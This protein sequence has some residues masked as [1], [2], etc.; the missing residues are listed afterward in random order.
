ME[1]M[2]NYIT[3]INQAILSKV[4][5]VPNIVL[6]GE[7]LTT[8]SRISGLTRNL[9]VRQGGYIINVGN[10]EATHC[11]VGF[12]LMMSGVTSVLFVKQLDFMLLGMDHF[13]NT[14]NFIRCQFDPD[15]Y[16]SFTIIAIVC[17]QGYQGPHSSFNAL[18]DM[19]SVARVPGYAITNKRDLQYIVD[20]QLTTPGFRFVTLSQKMFPAEFL[21]MRLVYSAEDGSVFQYE[22]GDDA[23]IVCFNFSLPDGL[24]LVEKLSRS[25]ISSSLFSVNYV[26]FASWERII[27]DVLRTKRIVVIDDSKSV[28]LPLYTLLNELGAY[29]SIKKTIVTRGSNIDFGVCADNLKINY[30][31]IIETV[32]QK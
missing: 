7:N 32:L 23:T 10:C 9:E 4:A 2:T 28:Q 1:I 8:G 18:G 11:G 25:G 5:E 30:N 15:K 12:G 24:V 26:P 31:L 22:E 27:R 20:T 6:Y 3:A 29:P 13:V 16:G 19:C 21:D 14:Y 17:N